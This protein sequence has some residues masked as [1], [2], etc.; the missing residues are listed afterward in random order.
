MDHAVSRD[1]PRVA[2]I[3]A[4]MTGLSCARELSRHGLAPV[5]LE[6]SRGLGGRMA[7]R[8]VQAQALDHG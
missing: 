7:S 5:V 8:R 4:G 2:V 1:T 3:G 6:K